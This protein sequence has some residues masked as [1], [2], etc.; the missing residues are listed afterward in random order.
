MQ[1]PARASFVGAVAEWLCSGLQ[2]RVHRFDS[3]PRLQSQIPVFSGSRHELPAQ[4]DRGMVLNF[5]YRLRP[6]RRQHRALEAILESQ[7]QLYNAALEERIG[8]YRKAG[9]LRT[10]ADQCRALTQWRQDDA[11]GRALPVSLQRAT[12]KR[13]DDAY[14]AAFSRMCSA[15]RAGF[16]RFRGKGWFDSFGF[17]EFEGITLKEGRLRFRG[18]RGSLRVRWHRPLPSASKPK[19]CAFRRDVRGWV[20]AFACE[21]TEAPTRRTGRAVGLDLGLTS[22]ATLSDGSVIPNLRIGREGRK[23][24]RVAQRAL[25][26]KRER[27]RGRHEARKAL[28]RAHAIMARRRSNHLHQ[29]S[30]R[31]AREFDVIVVEKLRVG[32]LAK[33][34][35]TKAVHDVAW[36]RFT[37]MLRYK[38]ARAGARF[39]EVDPRGTSQAC[40]AC[41]E[42][43]LKQL[44]DRVHECFR[45]GASM[46]R[47]FNAALNILSRAGVGPG[48]PNAAG[49]GMRAGETL[50]NGNAI[51]RLS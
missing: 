1:R 27:S 18:M 13:L 7:R 44:G 22:L 11:E 34:R 31:L 40:S 35:L 4:Y 16:P 48:L 3:G 12:L 42:Q 30:A 21:V 17:R 39:V 20:V 9:E 8:A 23:R 5:V 29:A 49:C 10:Y 45:C 50:F 25:A 15:K 41:G 26:R 2:S 43:V 24:L 37:S 51:T 33:S 14:R 32:A 28:R 6:T 46:D 36:T 38:A 47:D 19:S